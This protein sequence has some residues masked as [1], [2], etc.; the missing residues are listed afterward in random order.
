MVL[1]ERITMMESDLLE[2]LA[3][4]RVRAQVAKLWKQCV[5][6]GTLTGEQLDEMQTLLD[7]QTL[8][9]QIPMSPPGMICVHLVRACR[10]RTQFLVAKT[11][12]TRYAQPARYAYTACT[13]ARMLEFMLHSSNRRSSPARGSCTCAFACMT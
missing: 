7:F 9:V 6:S 10:W 8:M 11:R 13:N 3:V 5:E 4:D 12:Q 1:R 2:D